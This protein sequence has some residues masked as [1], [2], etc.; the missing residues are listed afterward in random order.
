MRS[1]RENLCVKAWAVMAALMLLLFLS[2][3][4][5]AN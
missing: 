5:I 4:D 1:S 2:G 3:C